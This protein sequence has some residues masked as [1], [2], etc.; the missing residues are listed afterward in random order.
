VDGV[1]VLAEKNVAFEAEINDLGAQNNILERIEVREGVKKGLAV[2]K[3]E[4]WLSDKEVSD[5]K[6]R[7]QQTMSQV[8]QVQEFSTSTTSPHSSHLYFS[9]FFFTKNSPSLRRLSTN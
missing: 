6:Q 1:R 3:D 5:I 7:I 9:P 8:S 2:L 4:G